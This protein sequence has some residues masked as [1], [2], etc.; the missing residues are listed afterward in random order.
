MLIFSW[1]LLNVRLNKQKI[2]LSVILN[3]PTKHLERGYTFIV[4]TMSNISIYK[5]SLKSMCLKNKY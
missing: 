4:G 2:N 1:L 5:E 3:V